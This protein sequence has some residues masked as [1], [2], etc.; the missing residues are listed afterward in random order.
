[1]SED[2]YTVYGGNGLRKLGA[3]STWEEAKAFAADFELN[4]DRAGISAPRSR[5]ARYENGLP[6][7]TASD[8]SA[9]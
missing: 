6:K 7:T 9:T 5:I 3:F 2:A 1:M 4:C 8:E